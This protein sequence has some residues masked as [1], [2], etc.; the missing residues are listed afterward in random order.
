MEELEVPT[1][2]PAGKDTAHDAHLSRP[3]IN[4]LLPPTVVAEDSSFLNYIQKKATVRPALFVR[5]CRT[6][7]RVGAACLLLSMS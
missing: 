1:G 6:W 7:H 4:N 2:V 5:V 3:Y